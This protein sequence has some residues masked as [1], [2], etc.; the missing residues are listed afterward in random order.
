MDT[1]VIEG[2]ENQ[3]SQRTN[4]SRERENEG[5][6]EKE[7][8]KDEQSICQ[9]S[10]T[11]EKQAL[12]ITAS[13]KVTEIIELQRRQEKA[14][15]EL[16]ELLKGLG[17]EGLIHLVSEAQAGSSHAPRDLLETTIETLL[18]CDRY[19]REALAVGTKLQ[20]D[21]LRRRKKVTDELSWR[22]VARMFGVHRQT[23]ASIVSA[24]TRNGTSPDPTSAGT[25]LTGMPER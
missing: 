23:L 22:Q 21:R 1:R 7:R 19:C 4:I 18:N 5:N 9:K 16:Q 6:E 14:T 12:L 13:R 17:N 10:L 20:H 3:Y 25:L 24:G 2:R 8:R 15:L 11:E